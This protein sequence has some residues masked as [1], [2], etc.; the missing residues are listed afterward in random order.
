MVDW[1]KAEEVVDIIDYLREEKQWDLAA[2]EADRQESIK[3][4][5]IRSYATHMQLWRDLKLFHFN[6]RFGVYSEELNKE[7]FRKLKI[8]EWAAIQQFGVNY[9]VKFLKDLLLEWEPFYKQDPI[10]IQLGLQANV[11]NRFHKQKKQF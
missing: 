11:K 7:I 9:N 6:R 3:K 10:H 4:Y 2:M 8:I 5:K 1:K